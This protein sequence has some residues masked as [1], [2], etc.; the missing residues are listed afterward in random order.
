ML[1]N[2]VYAI[3]LGVGMAACLSQG[4]NEVKVSEVTEAEPDSEELFTTE[5]PAMPAPENFVIAQGRVG[6]VHLNMPIE[7]MRE[8]VPS[9]MAITDTTL[10]LE[11]QPSTSYL[12]RLKNSNKGLLI[13]QAC[14]P[15]CKV[16]RI[17]VQHPDFKT[18]KGIGIGSKYGE[19]QKAHPI[20][21]V[22]PGE[23]GFVAVSDDQ[24]LSFILDM[25]HISTEQLAQ[26]KPEDVP[27]N[28]I[29][30]SLMIY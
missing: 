30:K 2:I 7:N 13:E 20:S 22:S 15:T 26:L 3:L 19:V 23:A 28:T 27:A 4:N 6:Y 1:K 12:L 17:R 18:S 14:E 21:Y 11:G 8:S 29:V 9:G 16:W 24:K 25:S 10:H 5:G